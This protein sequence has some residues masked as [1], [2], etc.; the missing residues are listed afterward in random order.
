MILFAPTFYDTLDSTN[1]EAKRL[2]L[3]GAKEGIVV[4]AEKQTHGRGRLGRRWISPKGNLYATMVVIPDKEL[5]AIPSLALVTGLAIAQALK[6]LLSFSHPVQVKWPNDVLLASQKVCGILVETDVD[7]SGKPIC[8][9]GFGVNLVSSPEMV[10][11]PATSLHHYLARPVAPEEVLAH[12]LVK[13]TILYEEWLENGFKKLNKPWSDTAFG[14]G[15][16]IAVQLQPGVE[17]FG[18][19]TG[20]NEEGAL[21]IADEMGQVQTLYSTEIRFV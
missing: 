4:V 3:A 12:I 1:S 5:I 14:I 19:Y 16:H 2:M 15:R 20:V 8:Y 9:I 7:N 21:L 10:A 18:K 6:E 17:T 13:F 11:F